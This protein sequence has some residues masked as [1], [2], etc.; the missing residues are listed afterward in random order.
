MTSCTLSIEFAIALPFLWADPPPRPE[1][2]PPPRRKQKPGRP[3]ASL[4]CCRAHKGGESNQRGVWEK[5]EK[6]NPAWSV[7][8][9]QKPCS[10]FIP[11]PSAS[12]RMSCVYCPP[13]GRGV[14][15]SIAFTLLA[16]RVWGVRR[17]GGV[18]DGST[19]ERGGRG[20][21][22]GS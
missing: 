11:A 1:G 13:F 22:A 2:T 10:I 18:R 3:H 4:P 7:A 20:K 19:E 15:D 9:A 14:V 17:G 5:W 21:S 16:R 8:L 12:R 6:A